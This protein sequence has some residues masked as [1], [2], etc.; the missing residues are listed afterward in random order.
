[1]SNKNYSY[2]KEQLKKRPE[3]LDQ[4]SKRMDSQGNL[5]EVKVEFDKT[6]RRKKYK[7]K[8]SIVGHDR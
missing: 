1:M 8:Y 3:L 7:N 5:V 2:Y 6:F 4:T